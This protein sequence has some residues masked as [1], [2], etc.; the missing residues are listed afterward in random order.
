MVDAILDTGFSGDLLLPSETI[1]EA[2]LDPL[3]QITAAL[4]DG[5]LTTMNTWL[6]TI[7]WHGQPRNVV[8]LESDGHPLIGMNLLRGN[9][10]IM[11]V[12]E[13]GAVII[14]ELDNP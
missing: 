14:E 13:N 5:S 9:R 12:I 11:D 8:V 6:G 7:Q 4:A 2:A 1:K 10:V 3:D